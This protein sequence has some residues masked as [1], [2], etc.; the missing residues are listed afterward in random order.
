M[1]ARD[2]WSCWLCHEPVDPDAPAGSPASATVDHVVPRSRGGRTVPENLR[3]AHRR[4]NGARANHLPELAWPGEFGLL[5]A[6]SLWRSIRRL[7]ARPGTAETV[8]LAPTP[9][10]A[11][12]AGEWAARAAEAFV[13]AEWTWS[14]RPTGVGRCH[15]V[16][17]RVDGSPADPGRPYE[18]DPRALSRRR[19][20]RR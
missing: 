12:R 19:R 8:A 14:V 17:L 2:G 11:E 15:V 16:A 13:G 9:E 4:C 18:P 5:D 20:R 7:G 1:A 3:L 6:P 10:L